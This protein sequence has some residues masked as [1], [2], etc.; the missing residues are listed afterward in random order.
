LGQSYVRFAEY[1]HKVPFY[2]EHVL[3]LFST[4]R[5]VL[6]DLDHVKGHWNA[7]NTESLPH[8]KPLREAE[9]RGLG[10]AP[11]KQGLGELVDI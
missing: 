5:R 10:L 2:T 8:P 1:G 11:E 7:H 3:S 6:L 4:K 9:P